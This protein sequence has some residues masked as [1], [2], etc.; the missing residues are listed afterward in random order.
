MPVQL[1]PDRSALPRRAHR[2]GR[3]PRRRRSCTPTTAAQT[4][5]RQLDGRAG[6]RAGPL[7]QREAAA[8]RPTIRSAPHADRRG[9]ALRGAGRR[10][11]PSSTSGSRRAPTA[12]SSAPSAWSCTPP[13]AARH[14]APW[15]HA[16]RQPEGPA[17]VRGARHRARRLHRRRAGPAAALERGDAR[18]RALAS[19]YKGTLFGVTAARPVARR[20]RPAR[21]RAAQRR[22]RARAGS[23]LPTGLQVGLTAGTRQDDGALRASSARPAHCC[24]SRDDGASFRPQPPSAPLPAAGRRAA[25][26]RRAGHRRACAARAASTC[27]DRAAGHRTCTPPHPRT[28]RAGRRPTED[29][30]T[31]SGSRLER[32]VFNHRLVVMVVC[33][34]AHAAAGLPGRDAAD[35]QRQ[36]REDASRTGH[37]YIQ[38]YLAEQG[39]PARAGQR[40][41]HR[42]REHARRHLR[43]ALPRDAARRSTTSSSCTPGV[44][45][46]WMKSLWTPAVRWIEVTEEGFER[47]PG[48]AR[49]LRRLARRDRASCARNIARSAWSAAS[50]ATTSSPA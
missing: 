37:P 7:L 9:A 24:A 31:R 48:D 3:R 33:L 15:L 16:A 21:H 44:D 28:V 32:L 13:T 34:A 23:R 22:R 6:R 11:S 18:F 45:R 2:L 12:S 26:K 42:G 43:P 25:A 1:G 41:A 27:P 5:T 14:W 30:D 29:F 40:A 10:T 49:Q 35:A 47:R 8:L 50:S 4:W 20:L 19:P 46:A 38:N 17:P 39:G 36:L